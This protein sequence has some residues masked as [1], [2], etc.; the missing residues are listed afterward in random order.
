[1]HGSTNKFGQQQGNG[2]PG[3]P[4]YNT[5]PRKK[6]D[7]AL[8]PVHARLRRLFQRDIICA[9]PVLPAYPVFSV[10]PRGIG[11]NIIGLLSRTKVGSPLLIGFKSETTHEGA[12]FFEWPPFSTGLNLITAEPVGPID[13][14]FGIRP[15][16]PFWDII[17]LFTG[18]TISS[19]SFDSFDSKTARESAGVFEWSVSFGIATSLAS[20][21]PIKQGS[22]QSSG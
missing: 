3:G 21:K 8:G 15:G 4:S 19:P 7:P 12:R 9:E 11:R 6:R 2:S 10:G 13:P 14:V 16:G 1:M 18:L 17:R 20:S 22:I 5:I